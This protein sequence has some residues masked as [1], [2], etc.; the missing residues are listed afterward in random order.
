MSLKHEE[1]RDYYQSLQTNDDLKTSACTTCDVS[2]SPF[3]RDTLAQIHPEVLTKFYGCG[4]VF[5]DV[6]EGLTV[7]DLGS[8]FVD[9]NFTRSIPSLHDI[10]S[11][12]DVIVLYYQDWLVPM[13]MLLVLI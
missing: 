9:F 5:P 6:L 10:L 4:L 11:D 1:V 2:L 8:G 3:V 12:L 13:G 7:L